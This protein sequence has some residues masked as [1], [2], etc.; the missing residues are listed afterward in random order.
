MYILKSKSDL[1]EKKMI[2]AISSIEMVYTGRNASQNNE[3]FK[4]S[5]FDF[6][7]QNFLKK[8]VISSIEMAYCGRKYIILGQKWT[9]FEVNASLL[10]IR[11][12]ASQKN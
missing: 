7:F 4:L 8:V 6:R 5:N 1:C 10:Y 11:R 9:K 3:K 2:F 12:E